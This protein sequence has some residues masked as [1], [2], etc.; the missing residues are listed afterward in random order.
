[1]L[2]QIVPVASAHD[3]DITIIIGSLVAITTALIGMLWLLVRTL[4]HSRT[5]ADEARMA[6]AAVNNTGPG[7][8]RLYD[9]IGSMQTDIQRLV[10]TQ[11]DF[12]ELGWQSLP[13]DLHDAPSLTTTIRDLQRE[14]ETNTTD[15]DAIKA[16]LE[17]LTDLL[18]ALE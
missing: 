1:M 2:Q 7:E 11:D 9:R 8:H 12:A 14:A 10:N 15:H 5:A 6:N 4:A 3:G 13:D 17:M 16:Q 18:R